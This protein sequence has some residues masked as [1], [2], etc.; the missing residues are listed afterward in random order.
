MLINPTFAKD[1]ALEFL[2]KTN[3]ELTP[4]AISGTVKQV[5]QLMLEG[6]SEEEIRYTLSH[7]LKYNKSVYSF[8]YI[9]R[10]IED[11][12]IRL[13]QEEKKKKLISRAKKEEKKR[14]DSYKVSSE[15]GVV[16]DVE[17]S[18]RNRRKA[19]RLG[20]ESRERKK[21]YFDLFEGQ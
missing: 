6:Y 19:E 13:E 2:K 12:S 18:E 16:E 1:I 7:V 21:S 9:V 14:I 3:Q 5:K 10:A 17:A 15:G 11:L 8:G 20:V 4:R